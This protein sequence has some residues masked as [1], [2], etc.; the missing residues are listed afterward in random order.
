M[1]PRSRARTMVAL[2]L[3]TAAVSV[4]THVRYMPTGTYLSPFNY[5]PLV[6]SGE[7]IGAVQEQTRKIG[8][9]APCS[10][11]QFIHKITPRGIIMV[12]AAVNVLLSVV[13][14]GAGT[15]TGS[16]SLIADA[17]HSCSDLV[18]DGLCLLAS[19][20]PA[21]ERACTLGIAAMLSTAGVAMMSAPWRL[22]MT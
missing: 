18:T 12:G 13:K 1:G 16:P 14:V 22:F 10:L 4:C 5:R 7:R 6:G 8:A 9:H 15:L 19:G 3:F 17:G 2:T 21:W 20:T 11:H